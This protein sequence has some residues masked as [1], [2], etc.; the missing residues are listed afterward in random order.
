MTQPAAKAIDRHLTLL[1]PIWMP[2]WTMR[3]QNEGPGQNEHDQVGA[4]GDQRKRHHGIEQNRQ[5]K[6]IGEVGGTLGR[7]LGPDNPPESQIGIAALAIHGGDRT[8]SGNRHHAA[9]HDGEERLH[10][11]GIEDGDL[12]HWAATENKDLPRGQ[13]DSGNQP[14]R[15]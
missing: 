5:L 7:I 6:L 13:A 11:H 14:L 1:G 3:R 8:R 2:A 10:E 15:W 12:V 9:Y 4:L